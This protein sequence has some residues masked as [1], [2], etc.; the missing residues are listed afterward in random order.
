LTGVELSK[1][2]INKTSFKGATMTD[3]NFKEYA[4][5]KGHSNAVNSVAYSPDGKTIASCS[6]DNT[7]RLFDTI[8]GK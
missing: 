1:A 3:V 4:S 5:L 7:I 6:S 8:T 2:V